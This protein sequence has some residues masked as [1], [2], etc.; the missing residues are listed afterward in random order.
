MPPSEFVAGGV[1]LR[2]TLIVFERDQLSGY[3]ENK[4]AKGAVVVLPAEVDF[5]II[6]GEG[7]DRGFE[8]EFCQGTAGVTGDLVNVWI[9]REGD[10][11]V[12][13]IP[14]LDVLDLTGIAGAVVLDGDAMDASFGE[15]GEDGFPWA[16]PRKFALTIAVRSWWL[17][18]RRKDRTH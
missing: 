4:G 15:G 16:Q 8:A 6:P 13:G 14:G 3:I 18:G 12:A 7:F 2:V 17:S 10:P 9:G 11:F 5:E 1:E